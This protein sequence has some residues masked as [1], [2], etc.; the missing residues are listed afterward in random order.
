MFT[1]LLLP[2]AALLAGLAHGGNSE[3]S[4]QGHQSEYLVVDFASLGGTSSRGNS[5]NN[6]GWIAGYS[7]LTAEERHAALWLYGFVFDLKTVG[8]PNSSVTWSSAINNR[9]LIAGISQTDLPEPLGQD[10][11]CSFFFP[12]PDNTG[13]T[14]VGVVWE[15]GK[16]RELPRLGG[17]NSFATSVNNRGEITGWSETD[18]RDSTCNQQDGNQVLQFLP[19][20]WG[21]GKDDIRQMPLISGDTSGTVNAINDRGQAVGISGICDIAV[22]RHSARHAVLWENGNATDLGNDGGEWWNTPT[23]I[24]RRGDIVGFLGSP[25]GPDG[26]LQAFLWTRSGGLQPLGTLANQETEHV[27]SEAYGINERR[28]VAGLSCDAQFSDCRAFLWEDGVMTDLN[29][30]TPGY[31]NVLLHARDISDQG[32]ITG[33]AFDADAGENLTYWAIPS[34]KQGGHGSDASV[35][36]KAGNPAPEVDLPDHVKREILHPLSSGRAKLAR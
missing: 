27:H 33:V 9:G 11:S 3:A 21:P 24:N 5:I 29:S 4:P 6:L 17:H 1:P 2:V 23:A 18:V 8:G 20:V 22:G 14:C 34:R 16:I 30:V 26:F 19:V 32:M 35:A 15:K 36:E 28:Q 31:D 10:W 7:N 13:F 25:E 12:P